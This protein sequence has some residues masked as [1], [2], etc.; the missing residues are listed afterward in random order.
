MGRDVYYR[1]GVAMHSLRRTV[2][3]DEPDLLRVLVLCMFGLLLTV[4]VV[5]IVAQALARGVRQR[6]DVVSLA[7]Q[8]RVQQRTA[9]K[10][11]DLPQHPEETV[12]AVTLV[13]H[14]L[15]HERVQPR[16]A[17]QNEDAPQSPAEVVE[18]VTSVPREPAHE[19]LGV[20]CRAWTRVMARLWK[21][22]VR[23]GV[24]PRLCE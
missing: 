20:H 6:N 12:E 1:W 13:P 23:S 3:S 21:A 15:P 22:R 18:A 2:I 16:T 4:I 24:L 8:E 7:P 5:K 19:K 11:E 9:E 14:E 17:E 10:I